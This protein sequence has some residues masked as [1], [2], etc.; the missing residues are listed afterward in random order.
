[1]NLQ[2]LRI[3]FG[4]HI[5]E[6]IKVDYNVLTISIIEKIRKA[7]YMLFLIQLQKPFINKYRHIT[8]L[9]FYI[10]DNNEIKTLA[11]ISLFSFI[12]IIR[13]CVC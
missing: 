8:D 10:N 13:V 3:S 1:M 12:T 5:L 11:I 4:L 6:L 7:S 2:V 9:R